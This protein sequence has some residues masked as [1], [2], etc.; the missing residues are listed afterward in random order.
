MP[1][2]DTKPV[3]HAGLDGNDGTYFVQFSVLV[4]AELSDM[5]RA[6]KG[7]S[8][9]ATISDGEDALVAG[10]RKTVRHEEAASNDSN[11][12]RRKPISNSVRSIPPASP[13]GL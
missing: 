2:I 4:A 9:H 8:I 12:T 1:F 5:P 3:R 11:R 6:I 10:E 7:K 13:G